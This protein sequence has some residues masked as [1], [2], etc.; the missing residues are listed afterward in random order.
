M[1]A[2]ATSGWDP[3]RAVQLSESLAAGRCRTAA[4]A[5]VST[6]TFRHGRTLPRTRISSRH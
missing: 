2:F 5:T 6:P 4:G 1:I 3:T